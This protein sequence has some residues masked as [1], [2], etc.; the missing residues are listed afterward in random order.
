MRSELL[1]TKRKLIAASFCALRLQTCFIAIERGRFELSL[2]DTQEAEKEFEMANHGKQ[3]IAKFL[4]EAEGQLPEIEHKW[5]EL[6]LAVAA[7]RSEIDAYSPQ[8]GWSPARSRP[9]GG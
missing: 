3:V 6:R 9:F 8:E 1:K 7:L 4:S 2:G 5:A